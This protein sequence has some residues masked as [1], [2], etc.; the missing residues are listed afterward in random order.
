LTLLAFLLG[1]IVVVE[2]NVGG[3]EGF[4]MEAVGVAIVLD[5]F[6]FCAVGFND[7]PTPTLLTFLWREIISKKW[8]QWQMK[9]QR[10]ARSFLTYITVR[11]VTLFPHTSPNCLSY[12]S[13]SYFKSYCVD[14]KKY[15]IPHV[16]CSFFK[17]YI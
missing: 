9:N 4:G 14:F 12:S 7:L 11:C 16:I 1:F 2:L 8:R 10:S 15:N 5:V 13:I 6:L 3:G 17:M